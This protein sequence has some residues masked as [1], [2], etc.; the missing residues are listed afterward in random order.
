MSQVNQQEPAAEPAVQQIDRFEYSTRLE[1]LYR[2]IFD[3]QETIRFLDTKA[4]FC[5]TLLTAM[6]AAAFGPL[7][8]H[9]RYH[10]VHA[11]AL[12]IFAL[13]I[14]LTLALCLKVIFPT[15][16]LQGAFSATGP[17][18][19]TF[20]LP[21]RHSRLRILHSVWNASEYPLSIPHDVYQSSVVN[22]R[23]L[24][25]VHSL[26]DEVI[27]VSVL[28]QVKADRLRAAI[29]GLALAVFFFFVQLVL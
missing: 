6:M 5:V 20:Y 8:Q 4:A 28:R 25:L 9:H 21:H 1:F 15:V 16:H 24:D 26:C 10:Q 2:I 11:V 3:S 29:L 19:P 13:T 23:D 18:S 14:F 27:T 22:A 12:G 7:A 17:A